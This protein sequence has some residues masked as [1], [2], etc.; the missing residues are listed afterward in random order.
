LRILS[1]LNVNP[2]YMK[3]F[4]FLFVS[5]TIASILVKTLCH[6]NLKLLIL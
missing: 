3:H 4:F 2:S 1:T 6:F 5:D